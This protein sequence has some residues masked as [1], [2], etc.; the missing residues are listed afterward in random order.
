MQCE[1]FPSLVKRLNELN[2]QVDEN[3]LPH[4]R[5]IIGKPGYGSYALALAHAAYILSK[6]T[7]NKQVLGLNHPDLHLAFPVIQGKGSSNSDI[8]MEQWRKLSGENLFFNVQDWTNAMDADSNKLPI[9]SKYESSRI[10]QKLSLKSYQ[11]GNKV[12]IIWGA[13]TMNL[14]V[15]NKLLKLIEEPPE[16]TYLILLAEHAEAILPTVVSRCQTL[17]LPGLPVKEIGEVLTDEY[18]IE[19]GSALNIAGLS[20]GDFAR[21]KKF[22]SSDAEGEDFHDLFV[23]WMRLAYKK[24]LPSI[25]N[26]CDEIHGLK[27]ARQQQFVMYSLNFFRQC[28]LSAYLGDTVALLFGKEKDFAGKFG[29]FVHG[30]NVVPMMNILDEAHYHIERNG[31]AKLIFF[32]L[33]VKMIRLLH[34]KQPYEMAN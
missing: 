10:L 25:L 21:A 19:Q 28:M 3:K 34:S 8:F 11:G 27:R 6:D 32:D 23:T 1:K 2:V 16:K 17:V 31:S 22:G 15:S 12:M 20:E 5:L 33:S 4:A 7:H 29:K 26:W 18:G 13:D 24:D 9:I 14:T 30:G